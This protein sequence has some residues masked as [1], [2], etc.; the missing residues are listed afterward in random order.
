MI[1]VESVSQGVSL[2]ISD[3]MPLD[4]PSRYLQSAP[5]L[6]HMDRVTEVDR[7]V[8]DGERRMGRMAI[9]TRH[10]QDS[11]RGSTTLH[12]E[13]N[14]GEQKFSTNLVHNSGY[15][16]RSSSNHLRYSAASKHGHAFLANS[17]WP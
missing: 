6:T 12:Q 8:E 11:L 2:E 10:L 4:L 14:Q 13:E 3:D 15:A 17:R 1:D 9:D 5:S 7:V 16:G